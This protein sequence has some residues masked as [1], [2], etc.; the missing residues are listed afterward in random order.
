MPLSNQ[1]TSRS[2]LTQPCVLA[3]PPGQPE[4]LQQHQRI[5]RRL[6]VSRSRVS[7][8]LKNKI[9]P[10]KGSRFPLASYVLNPP[11]TRP[12][13]LIASSNKDVTTPMKGE[14]G[15]QSV[16]RR[17]WADMS[18]SDSSEEETVVCEQLPPLPQV[19]SSSGR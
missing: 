1:P 13:L 2:V 10:G 19:A 11:G 15:K 9:T 14:P 8:S 6:K 7:G 12:K 16:F 5:W 3:S 4:K 18:D 17:A